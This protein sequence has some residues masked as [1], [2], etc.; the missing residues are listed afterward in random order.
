MSKCLCS[1]PCEPS[2][3]GRSQPPPGDSNRRA[4]LKDAERH[5][6]KN[7]PGTRVSSSQDDRGKD[8]DFSV[9]SRSSQEPSLYYSG[10][11]S[12]SAST[13]TDPPGS[14]DHEGYYQ[15]Y[16]APDFVPSEASPRKPLPVF[17]YNP[18]QQPY[19]YRESDDNRRTFSAPN[20]PSQGGY[21]QQQNAPEYYYGG[22]ERPSKDDID[23]GA[24]APTGPAED[25]PG[26]LEQL[27][28]ASVDDQA[29]YYDKGHEGTPG[30][31]QSEF[32]YDYTTS[33]DGT[34]YYRYRTV[35]GQPSTT[36]GPS[37][38]VPKWSEWSNWIL[39]PEQRSPK[40]GKKRKS[41]GK[42][43]H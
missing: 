36:G 40:D 38:S 20:Y 29:S 6:Y 1:E 33:S 28:L 12:S 31:Q 2:E 22:N 15:T 23:H 32:E 5:R 34:S 30:P 21:L 42:H 39:T 37:A 43:R 35:V 27:S 17:D 8:R 24:R 13:Y 9:G 41:K 19:S 4:S 10:A 26:E 7:K 3:E 14:S 11:H 16:S 25:L 18:P